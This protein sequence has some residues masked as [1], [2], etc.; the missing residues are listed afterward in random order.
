VKRGFVVAAV[1]VA[2][3][4]LGVAG[5][6]SAAP[7]SMKIAP[8]QYFLGAV[9]GAAES[10]VIRVVCPGPV[11]EDGHPLAGQSVDASLLLPP[12]LATSG[13]TGRATSI[14]VNL[15]YTLGPGSIGVVANLGRL[16][17]Y[18][19]PL[20]IPTSLD[21]PCSGVGSVSFDPIKGGPRAHPAIATVRFEN[22]AVTPA[23]S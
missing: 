6:S 15:V 14:A 2:S 22:I 21:V 9:N 18:N 13:F 23:T 20:A 19:L 17:F 7:R 11:G 8:N 16:R 12:A 1:A 3:A 10:A 4:F 5:A